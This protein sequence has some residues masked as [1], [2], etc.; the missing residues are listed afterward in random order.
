MAT[1]A[2]YQALGLAAYGNK[3]KSNLLDD[4]ATDLALWIDQI[5]TDVAVAFAANHAPFSATVSEEQKLEFYKSRLFN[6]DGSPNAQG[7]TEELARLGSDGFGQVYK[8]VIKRWPELRVP[9]PEAD[10]TVPEQWPQMPP[11]APPGPPVGPP[12]P[13]GGL[14]PGPPG[15]APGLPGPPGAGPLVPPRPP[16]MPPGR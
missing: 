10:L 7:R 12:R 4:V 6:A 11:G 2:G 16:M 13:P 15:T 14:P 9:T 3:S 8:A 5:S 1:D